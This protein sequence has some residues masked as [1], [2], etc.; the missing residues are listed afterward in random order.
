[1]YPL[2]ISRP[3]W[4]KIFYKNHQCSELCNTEY[5]IVDDNIRITCQTGC[6]FP[7]K[8]EPLVIHISDHKE[9]S[10]YINE[11][12]ILPNKIKFEIK[13]PLK[14]PVI[15]DHIFDYKQNI[16][17]KDILSIFD[18]FYKQ[19]Y[20]NEE[21]NL[22]KRE[23]DIEKQCFECKTENFY[24]ENKLIYYIEEYTDNEHQNEIAICSICF[25]ELKT[26]N[27]FKLKNCNHIF[28]KECII[29]WFN[30]L[31]TNDNIL[32]E[33]E[34]KKSNSC[35]VCRNPII[36]C[37]KCNSTQKITEKYFG[38][39]PPFDPENLENIQDRPETNGPYGIH[40]LYYEELFFKGIL[41]NKI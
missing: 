2:R 26:E 36:F 17:L 23:W 10:P 18:N 34:T 38:V 28:H 29:K 15:F 37:S 3:V 12:I 13:Y 9:T 4:T 33:T 24:S 39:V 8:I 1:M 31:K 35:P 32:G 41:F 27:S 16:T 14:K 19:I 25:E 20:K 40:T 21:K 30:T 7:E 6:L 11:E 5:E 22:E